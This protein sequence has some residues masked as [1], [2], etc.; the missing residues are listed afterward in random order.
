MSPAELAHLTLQLAI[1][2]LGAKL[3]GVLFKKLKQPEALG[4]LLGGMV[5]GPFALGAISFS[6]NRKVVSNCKSYWRACVDVSDFI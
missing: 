1:L 4:E 3:F 5:V 2:L 6:R